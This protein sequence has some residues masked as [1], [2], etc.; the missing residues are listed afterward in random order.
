MDCSSIPVT[1]R[2]STPPG[3][4]KTCDSGEAGAHTRLKPEG[5]LFDSDLSHQNIG[6]V[7]E[8]VLAAAS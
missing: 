7:A 4:T 6:P 3:P 1:A 5:R 8:L 2:G